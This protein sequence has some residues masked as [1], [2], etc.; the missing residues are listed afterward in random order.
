MSRVFILA[1]SGSAVLV[2]AYL[3]LQASLDARKSSRDWMQDFHAYAL[4]VKTDEQFAEVQAW[5]E[6]APEVKSRWRA[7]RATRIRVLQGQAF[8]G[9][10]HLPKDEIR[11]FLDLKV[12][13]GEID[14]VVVFPSRGAKWGEIVSIVDECRKSR[15]KIVLLNEHEV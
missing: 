5:N 2:A 14:H 13:S 4:R 1:V 10:T 15:V 7:A 11:G 6:A 3:G 9:D 12:A 8:V